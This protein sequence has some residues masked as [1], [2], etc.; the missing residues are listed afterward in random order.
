MQAVSAPKAG[1]DILEKPK[2]LCRETDEYSSI[3]QTVI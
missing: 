3:I 1:L 2:I